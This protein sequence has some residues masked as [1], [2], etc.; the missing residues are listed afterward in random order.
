VGTGA[1]GIAQ[2]ENTCSALTTR[3]AKAKSSCHCKAHNCPSLLLRHPASRSLRLHRD[4]GYQT[5]HPFPSPPVHPSDSIIKLTP[6]KLHTATI[7]TP[8]PDLSWESV[9]I[10]DWKTERQRQRHT[11]GYKRARQVCKEVLCVSPKHTAGFCNFGRPSPARN[12]RETA[13]FAAPLA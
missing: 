1:A 9:H 5:G 4:Q 2:W 3:E 12:H 7:S 8:I 13:D 10:F 11:I 6:E